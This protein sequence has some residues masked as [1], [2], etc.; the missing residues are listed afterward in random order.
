MNSRERVRRIL[1]FEEA[2]RPAIDLGST[3]M[4]GTSAW[5]YAVLRQALGLGPAPVRV[6]DLYQ[7][8]AEV[9]ADVLDAVGA[10]FCLLP[11]Q[12]LPLNLPYGEWEPFGFW[13]GQL[14]DVPRGFSPMREP[15]GSLEARWQRD[16]ATPQRMRLPFGGR[17][18][19][20]LPQG[21][22]DAFD[23]PH[24][25][26]SDWPL[27]TGYTDSFL[28][29]EEECARRLY[30]SCERALVASPPIGAPQGYADT[31]LWAMQMATEPQHCHDFMMASAE[32][33]ARCME[34]YMQAVGRYV[35][36]VNISGTDFGTQRGEMFRP[37]L[38]ADFYV[39]A[40]RPVADVIHRYPGV[41]TWIHCCGSVPHLVEHFISAGV[42]CL[43]PVQWTAA[44]MDLRWLK[45]TFGRRLVFWGGVASS[46]TTLPFGTA[47]EVE[48][49]VSQVLDIMAPG[50]GYVV[51]GVHNILPEVPVANTVAMY[52]TALAY[53][54]RKG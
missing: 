41:K 25:A 12:E 10:D 31:Y 49:E 28:R 33:R 52:R 37:H 29:R 9:D 27:P 35:Q 16:E 21:R 34:Q 40:W 26:L 23:I 45:E 4:T 48:Q 22:Q 15:D 39:P 51:N 24:L 2:D 42:D 38:F 3:R 6:F 50:G 53:R 19:D 7:M 20:R 18:F 44:G 1:S 5:T 54:N 46:Q 47:Q 14:L 30:E 8:L 43:N 36:V 32:A 13:D 11:P 17:F